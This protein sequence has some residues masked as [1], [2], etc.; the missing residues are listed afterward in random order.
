MDPWMVQG[1]SDGD[2]KTPRGGLDT[3]GLDRYPYELSDVAAPYVDA[4]CLHGGGMVRQ[5]S[6]DNHL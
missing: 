1:W 3:L 2:E 4:G 5:P 6:G